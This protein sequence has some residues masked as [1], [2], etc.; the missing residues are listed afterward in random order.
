MIS[1]KILSIK[2]LPSRTYRVP[3]H[4]CEIRLRGHYF[5]FSEKTSANFKTPTHFYHSKSSN[6]FR[7][8]QSSKLKPLTTFKPVLLISNFGRNPRKMSL[9]SASPQVVKTDERSPAGFANPSNGYSNETTGNI[10]LNPC[11]FTHCNPS[12]NFSPFYN[13][14]SSKPTICIDGRQQQR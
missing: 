2:S 7:L 9:P 4:F 11:S 6:P 13:D 12:S 3:E 5:Q 10:Q 1:F 14:T 8:L